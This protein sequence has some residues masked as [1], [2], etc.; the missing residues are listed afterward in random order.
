MFQLCLEV[1]K[2]LQEEQ[3]RVFISKWGKFTSL[4]S[5]ALSHSQELHAVRPPSF[6]RYNIRVG[7]IFP[8]GFLFTKRKAW[9]SRPTKQATLQ[10]IYYLLLAFRFCLLGWLETKWKIWPWFLALNLLCSTR[11][12]QQSHGRFKVAMPFSSRLILQLVA[13]WIFMLGNPLFRRNSAELI[14]CTAAVPSM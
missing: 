14:E 5:C 11:N 2:E 8:L 13:T 12:H 3:E 4:Y 1:T 10:T 9:P 6:S 7:K